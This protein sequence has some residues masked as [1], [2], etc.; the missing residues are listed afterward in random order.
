[1]AHEIDE[2]INKT[3]TILER[4]RVAC[5]KV[6]LPNKE[7]AKALHDM[8]TDNLI[9][10]IDP[11]IIGSCVIAIIK[12]CDLDVYH[13]MIEYSTTELIATHVCII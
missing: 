6:V 1:M 11:I 8:I 7:D 5:C 9:F 4:D 2:I 3:E 12:P 10:L 13:E